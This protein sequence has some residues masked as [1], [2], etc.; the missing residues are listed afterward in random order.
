MVVTLNLAGNAIVDPSTLL[1]CIGLG[2]GDSVDLS[3][4]PFTGLSAD[5]VACIV[6][7]LSERGV[8]VLVN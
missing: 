2:A 1:A 8:T 6:A 3:W 5:D 7:L 4:N